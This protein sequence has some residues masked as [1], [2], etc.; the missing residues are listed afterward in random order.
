MR[1]SS[2]CCLGVLVCAV[3]RAALAPAL[4][5]YSYTAAANN[6]F[7]S[8]YPSSPV[9]NSSGEFVGVGYDFSGVGWSSTNMNKSYSL[10]G[11]KHFLYA[12]HYQP[13][14]GETI[15]FTPADNVVIGYT[16]AERSGPLA[17]GGD[18]AIG[19]FEEA[20]PSDDNVNHYSILFKGYAE[21]PYI[22]SDLLVYGWTSRVGR[23]TLDH[24]LSGPDLGW[25]DDECTY[26]DMIFDDTS[27]GYVEE[28][29]SGDSG[30]PTF[31][32]NGTDN[33][34]YL[35]GAHWA[36]YASGP[37]GGID[38]FLAHMLPEVNA[39][40]AQTGYLPYVVT[41]ITAT[42]TGGISDRWGLNPNWSTSA[43]GDVL[44]SGKVVACASVLFDADATSEYDVDLDGDRTVTGITFGDAAGTNPFTITG[45]GTLTLGEA[46][47]KNLDDDMQTILTPV[48]LRE[49]QRWDPGSGGLLVSGSI[50]TTANGYLLLIEGQGDTTLGGAI[51]GNGG[52]AK[53]GPGT[54]AITSTGNAY[55]GK[56]FV[57][58]GTLA[59]GTNDAIAD[60]SNL[61]IDGG[62]FDLG[63]FSDTLGEVVLKSGSISGTTGV[64]TG[65][66]YTLESGTVGGIL[67]GAATVNKTTSG[68]VA[69]SGQNTYTGQTIVNGGT[70]LLTGSGSIN[71]T[72]DIE[73]DGG[74]LFLDSSESVDASINVI[75][76]VL[77][78]SGTINGDVVVGASGII[79]PAGI[80]PGGELASSGLGLDD[81]YSSFS[82]G[83]SISAVPEPTT[84]SLLAVGLVCLL[85]YARR[86]RTSSWR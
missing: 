82:S 47:L 29:Q 39:Y 43:P 60:L 19:M 12:A 10:L 77:T 7:S 17:A 55:T 64:L 80:Y 14:L 46:G 31:I 44:Q 21:S 78:G 30:S 54:L 81:A 70:L 35:S 38:S 15:N 16:V 83:I 66:S 25:P 48:V 74:M 84:F 51:S 58:G 36:K 49:S 62:T 72:S 13:V 86:R 65:S 32:V 4:D 56:T 59:L 71:S 42:W 61:T 33:E 67:G 8:G 45:A 26:Y 79:S 23:S 85:G 50:D 41:P 52:L 24:V 37:A 75:N 53:D 5:I 40:M 69:L 6:R 68:T 3:F 28:F 63:T 34:L 11:P 57:N 2:L 27:S 22:G 76:G 1:G 18:L 73:V 20:I 9:A